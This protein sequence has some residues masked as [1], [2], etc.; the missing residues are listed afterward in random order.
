M[1]R[2]LLRSRYRL[3]GGNNADV[4]IHLKREKGI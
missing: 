2:M 3:V 4:I 1:T